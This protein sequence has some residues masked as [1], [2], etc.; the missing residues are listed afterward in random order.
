MKNVKVTYFL[1]V[2]EF[3][4]PMSESQFSNFQKTSKWKC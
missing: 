1:G 4:V 3:I 2:E